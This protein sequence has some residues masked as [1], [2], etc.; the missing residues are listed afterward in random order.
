MRERYPTERNRVRA[1]VRPSSTISYSRRPSWTSA[2]PEVPS[3]RVDE[4]A[5]REGGQAELVGAALGGEPSVYDRERTFRIGAVDGYREREVRAQPVV[6]RPV[7]DLVGDA[8]ERLVGAELE[9]R[10]D[11]GTDDVVTPAAAR[12]HVADGRRGPFVFGVDRETSSYG[13]RLGGGD[14]HGDRP[15]DHDIGVGR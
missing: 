3:E 8:H 9:R 7:V 15:V 14:A 4:A 5:R 11:G 10:A 12:P 13:T 2:S 1:S 6:A